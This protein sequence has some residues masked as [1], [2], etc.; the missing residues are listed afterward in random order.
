MILLDVLDKSWVVKLCR[1]IAAGRQIA[2]RQEKAIYDWS[3]FTFWHLNCIA[4]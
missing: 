4:G 1:V 3:Y 2:V